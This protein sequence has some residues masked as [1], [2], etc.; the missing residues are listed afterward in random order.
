MTDSSPMLRAGTLDDRIERLADFNADPGAGGI[1]REVYGPE[2]VAA[3]DHVAAMMRDEGLEVRF[4]S[5]GNLYGLWEGVDPEAPRVLTGS[6]IDTTL[7][8]GRYD[9]VVGVLGAVE[10]VASLRSA[11]VRPRCG[12]EVVAFAGEE[13]R[14][15]RGCIGSLAAVGG[16]SREDLDQ[17][18]DRDGVTLAQALAGAGFDPARLSESRIPPDR[19]GAFIELHIE[20]GAVLEAAGV[21]VGVV[22]RIAAPHDVRIVLSGAAMHAGATP[23]ALRHDALAG[24]AEAM[25]ELERLALASSS[26]TTVATVGVLRAL[27]GAINVI[28][29]EVTLEVDVRDVDEAVRTAV[30]ESF[31]AATAE[32]ATRRGLELEHEVIVR[33]PPAPCAESVVE[34]ARRACT[35][36]GTPYLEVASGAYHD[37]M[38][39]ARTMPMG[40]IFVPSVGGVSHSPLEHTEPADIAQGVEVL[41]RALA[42]LAA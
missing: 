24:A 10:A 15:G 42:H 25:V 27:P 22:T 30:V 4:D 40:M 1:T 5:F 33:E 39:L 9:G 3:C 29:G 7:N 38:V 19:Y 37:A 41:A 32:I 36:L 26:G 14:F 13:P 8:A 18:R 34:A 16:L 20:Q 17:M 11:G 12:I 35:E 23:M 31:V 6:H 28:P 2:Y 21:P